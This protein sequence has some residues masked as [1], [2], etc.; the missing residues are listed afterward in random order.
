MHSHSRVLTPALNA[1]RGGVTEP[2]RWITWTPRSGD[3]LVCTPPKCGTTWTQTILTMLVHGGPELPDTVPVLSPW[4]DANLGV[5]ADE[6]A[7]SIKSQPGRRVIKTHTP[8]DGFPIWE[9]VTVVAVYRHPLDVFFSLRKHVANQSE[10]SSA[11]APFLLPIS[12]SFKQFLDG[13]CERNDFGHDTLA[14][15]VTHYIETVCSDRLPDLK[16]FHYED[17]LGDGRRAVEQL[18]RAIGMDADVS[19][20]DRVAKATA[21][22]SM[23][24]NAANYTPVAGTGFWK[25]DGNFFD[26][27]TSRKWEG[28]LS[29][30]ELDLYDTR[31]NELV[32]ATS[33]RTWLENGN[34]SQK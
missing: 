11:D 30:E 16:L 27:A 8:A 6:V 13:K 2:E 14:K 33:A 25:S 15:I 18:A 20:I 31:M 21:F 23:K 4:V 3:I 5:P 12:Q 7:T 22:G 9:G 1:Y 26:S 29:E 34:G 28:Q 24:A 32:P 10:V 17:M 19:L